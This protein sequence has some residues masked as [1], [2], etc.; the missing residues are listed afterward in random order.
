MG[1]EQ[2]LQELGPGKQLAA[3]PIDTMIGKLG[4]GIAKAQAALDE[5]SIQTAMALADSWLNLP[6]PQ[7]PGELMSRSLLS[8]GFMPTFYQFTEASL[9]LRLE[10][11]WH[12][13]STEQLGVDA[14]ASAAVGP[15]A[16]AA[17]VSYDQGRKFGVDSS[18][19]THVKVNMVSVPPPTGFVTF[20][21]KSLEQA[22]G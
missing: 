9:E 12:V 21:Q 15:V 11:K 22:V 5:N 2:Q 8:L 16:V 20:I 6:D 1:F 18:M 19:M 17:S 4:I 7:K 14:K 3:L 13:E 10:M